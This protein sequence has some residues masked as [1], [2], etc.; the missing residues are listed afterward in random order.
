VSVY[1]CVGTAF[2]LISSVCSATQSVRL[3][4]CEGL[5]VV[6]AYDLWFLHAKGTHRTAICS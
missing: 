4:C 2:A 5:T 3:K 1:R 6:C